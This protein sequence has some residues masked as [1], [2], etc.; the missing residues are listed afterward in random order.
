MFVCL[1][2]T[3]AQGMGQEWVKI[4]RMKTARAYSRPK[5][6]PCQIDLTGKSLFSRQK[7]EWKY[8]DS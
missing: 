8:E 6:E 4:Y 3:R 7:K 2:K 5:P 1:Y